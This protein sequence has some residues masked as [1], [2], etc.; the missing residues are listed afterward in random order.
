MDSIALEAT[1][2]Q[3]QSAVK[4]SRRTNRGTS[5]RLRA[6][7]LARLQAVRLGRP[8]S[9]KRPLPYGTTPP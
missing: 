5:R 9:R 4:Y 2:R 1:V 8:A 3:Y 6:I 7:V